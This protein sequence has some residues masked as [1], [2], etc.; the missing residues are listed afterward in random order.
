MRLF[1]E[2]ALG[3]HCQFSRHD[4]GIVDSETGNFASRSDDVELR[5][6][7][8]GYKKCGLEISPRAKTSYGGSGDLASFNTA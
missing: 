8:I 1:L 2:G 5:F 7:S 3:L 4:C 6:E